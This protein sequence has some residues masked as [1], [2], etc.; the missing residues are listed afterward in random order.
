MTI[1]KIEGFMY[2]L[3]FGFMIAH[4]LRVAPYAAGSDGEAVSDVHVARDAEVTHPP[5][6]DDLPAVK[7]KIARV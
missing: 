1:D 2:G 4:L 3:G 6:S 5:P 7:M